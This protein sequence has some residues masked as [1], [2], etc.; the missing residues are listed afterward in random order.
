MFF[1]PQE[2][3]QALYHKITKKSLCFTWVAKKDN[4]QIRFCFMMSWSSGGTKCFGCSPEQKNAPKEKW[5]WHTRWCCRVSSTYIDFRKFNLLNWNNLR[6]HKGQASRSECVSVCLSA[7]SLCARM[8]FLLEHCSALESC[9]SV[10][11]H[12]SINTSCNKILFAH[13]FFT[14]QGQM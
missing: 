4:V 5:S 12:L 10:R 9:Q 11:D 2:S 6:I 1:N 7:C 14:A 3:W 8:I 13:Y